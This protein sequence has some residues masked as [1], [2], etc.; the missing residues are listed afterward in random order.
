VNLTETDRLLTVIQNIDKR[1]VD[2]PTVIVWQ[3]LLHDLPFA[4][5]LRAVTEHFREST[6]YLLPAHIVAGARAIERER[7]REDN[8]RRALAAEPE[9]DSRPLADRRQEIRDFVAKVRGVLPEG[10]ADALR[11]G[12]GH[13]RQ[14]RE[15][16]ERQESAE[17]NPHYDPTALA[18]LA[19]EDQP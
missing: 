14:V 5:C 8:H 4:D 6:E 7:V 2:D 1:I 12:H 9:T 18:R 17:P 19:A 10:N 13:W 11:Y 15:A 16:R 3:E